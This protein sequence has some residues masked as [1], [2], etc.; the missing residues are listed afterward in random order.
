MACMYGD[1][2]TYRGEGKGRPS[3]VD[4]GFGDNQRHWLRV[5]DDYGCLD[6]G[7]G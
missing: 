5:V 7:G 2:A 1:G 4:F 6:S 3:Y